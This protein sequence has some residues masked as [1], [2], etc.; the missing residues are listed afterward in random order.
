MLASL[1]CCINRAGGNLLDLLAAAHTYHLV[2]AV[3]RRDHPTGIN[4]RQR[5]INLLLQRN[6]FYFRKGLG[7]LLDYILVVAVAVHMLLRL[8]LTLLLQLLF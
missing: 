2:T 1:A 5:C 4:L 7:N 8:L 3:Q 6:G